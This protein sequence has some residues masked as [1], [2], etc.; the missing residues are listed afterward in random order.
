MKPDCAEWDDFVSKKVDGSLTA[1]EKCLEASLPCES[2]FVSALKSERCKIYQR[3]KRV[4]L[5]ETQENQKLKMAC[6]IA[7][8]WQR[9]VAFISMKL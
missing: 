5:I 9:A 1:S 3:A 2:Y 8:A 4:R 7:C 6:R